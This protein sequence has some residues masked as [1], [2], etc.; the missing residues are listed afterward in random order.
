[1]F[2]SLQL[3]AKKTIYSDPNVVKDIAALSKVQP[4]MCGKAFSCMSSSDSHGFCASC[5]SSTTLQCC[6]H[7]LYF[8][9][10]LASCA[11]SSSTQSCAPS[12]TAV[13]SFVWHFQLILKKNHRA[14]SSSSLLFDH[15]HVV[16]YLDDCSVQLIP[17][18]H[19]VVFSSPI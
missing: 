16:A 14:S 15:L 10:P 17:G 6:F 1:M 3:C 12:R 11:A 13:T 19:D 18:L 2:Q 7:S 4:L 9:L 8:T 5:T